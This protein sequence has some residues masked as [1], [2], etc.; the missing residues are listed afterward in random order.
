MDQLWLFLSYVLVGTI[1]LFVGAFRPRRKPEGIL[2]IDT[3][4]PMK[5]SYEIQ[6]LVPLDDLPNQNEVKLEVK[7][8]S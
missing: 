7:V 1:C 5:D 3:T 2:K 4:D 8:I 6:F